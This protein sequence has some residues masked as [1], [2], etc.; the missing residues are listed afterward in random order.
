MIRSYIDNIRFQYLVFTQP[1][2]HIRPVTLMHLI[3]SQY[4]CCPL[5]LSS[6][7]DVQNS[8]ITYT[9]ESDCAVIRNVPHV[10]PRSMAKQKACAQARQ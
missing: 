10:T 7:T 8:V 6:A 1:E 4:S 2:V 9:V 5:E 3:R